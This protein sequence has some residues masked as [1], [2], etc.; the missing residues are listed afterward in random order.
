MFSTRSRWLSVVLLAGVLSFAGTAT[1]AQVS[2]DVRRPKIGLVLSGGGARG[3]AHL[4]VIRVLEELLIPI[5]CI[6]GTSMG[7]VIGGLYAYGK[8]PAEMET[9]LRG[10]DWSQV[11]RDRP[12]RPQ[13]PWREKQGDAS[14]LVKFR[15]GF[16]GSEF[17]LP[18]G[19]LEGQNIQTMLDSWLIEA[20]RISDFDE[21]PIP[22]RVVATDI[23]NGQAVVL[24]RGRLGRAIRASMGIPSIFSPVEIDG[25]LLV[26]GIVANGLPVDV[27]RQMGAEIVIVVDVSTPP[28]PVGE[29]G[30]AFRMN[31]QVSSVLMR[32]ALQKQR[33]SITGDDVAIVPDLGDITPLDFN[34]VA[35]AL[36]KGSAA[37]RSVA[38][39]LRRLS[40]P[41]DAYES[42]RRA[43]RRVPKSPPTVDRIDIKT[44]TRLSESVIGSRIE[45]REGEPLDLRVLQRDVADVYGLNYFD[46]VGFELNA[47]AEGEP[48]RVDLLVDAERSFLAPSYLRFGMRLEDDFEGNSDFDV[49][50]ELRVTELNGW[51]AEWRN[52]L[53]AGA[54]DRVFSEF[55]Q[56]LD[57]GALLFAAVN[58]D[59]LRRPVRVYDQGEQIAQLQVTS[60]SPGLDVGCNLG[61]WGELRTGIRYFDG[62]IVRTI[63]DRAIRGYDSHDGMWTTS[64][65][66][67]TLDQYNFPSEG[68]AG[69]LRYSRSFD[70]L[71][72]TVD[73][74]WAHFV[75]YKALCTG[76]HI[77]VGLVRAG[78]VLSG[79]SAVVNAFSLGGLF[80]L[81]GYGP[82]QLTGNHYGLA[83]LVYAYQ[84]TGGEGQLLG[85]PIYLG[86]S[87]ETGNIWLRS[88]D[89][90]LENSLILSG[91]VWLGVDTYFGPAYFSY[92]FAEGGEHSV[93]LLFGSP[94]RG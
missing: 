7:A 2:P 73:Y 4:G 23:H 48:D 75:G 46:R 68:M 50:A 89:V 13:L 70:D 88:S 77:G 32:K 71:G 8:S 19:I 72:A 62:N 41:A 11:F 91:S 31:W 82:R 57:P 47:A 59:Y 36:Q 85:V 27:A 92:G 81:S 78:S 42:W 15:M 9:L 58:V 1:V 5:H 22:L 25:R 34:K 61:R 17:R 38:A 93:M 65:S 37:A 30:S 80:G 53:Q 54:T 28:A 56:P 79:D 52:I 66:F 6:T 55:Y 26:D 16:D 64:L 45:S 14:F 86:A 29:P 3:A 67:D 84:V 43:Q 10:V 87:A 40:V 90:D 39:R 21:L 20:Y 18:R 49:A 44:D 24:G 35:Q 12:L 51:G 74:E 63:G 76:R 83:A 60:T 94:F 33:D 69:E